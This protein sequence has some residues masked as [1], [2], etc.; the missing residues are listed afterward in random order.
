MILNIK[1]GF[2]MVWKEACSGVHSIL[3]QIHLMHYRKK[4]IVKT[5]NFL[6]G[7]RSYASHETSGSWQK[8]SDYSRISVTSCGFQQE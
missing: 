8:M 6:L 2:L 7:L 3:T 5:V 1:F 4:T